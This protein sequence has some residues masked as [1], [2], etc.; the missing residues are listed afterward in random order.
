M[1]TIGNEQT[2]GLVPC[3]GKGTRLG[4]PFSKELFP[5]VHSDQYNPIILYT[6]KA[7]KE[8]GISHIVFTINPGKTDLLGFLGNGEKFG[9]KFTFCIHP[10]PSS[11]PESINEA[12]HLLMSKTVLFAMPDTFVQP[13]NFLQRL[14]QIHETS[15]DRREVT[16]ACF[17]TVNPNKFGMVEFNKGTVV[18]IDDKPAKT[19][20]K[21]MWGAMIW[22]QAFF[23]NLS[24]FITKN[25]NKTEKELI[26]TDAFE[27]FIKKGQVKGICFDEGQYKDL[28][29]YN[30]IKDWSRMDL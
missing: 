24:L 20:L 29:T 16:L 11:L 19:D 28:G 26:L 30:E 12:S 18:R 23:E 5:N 10:V 3:A 6:I 27:P 9:M 13:N 7:M 15:A 25:K 17:Q 21:W 2:I 8:A 14:R 4:L 22:N 1:T